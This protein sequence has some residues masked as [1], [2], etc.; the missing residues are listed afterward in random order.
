M[1]MGIYKA[2]FVLCKR[3]FFVYIKNDNT[4]ITK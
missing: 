4:D 2:V 1:E 3:A